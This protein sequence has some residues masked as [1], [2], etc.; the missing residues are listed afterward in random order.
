MPLSA[1]APADGHTP[2]D[3]HSSQDGVVGGVTDLLAR[4][5]DGDADAA[6]RA[7]ELLRADLV[8]VARSLRRKLHAGQ[9]LQTTALIHEAY[10]RMAG[11][12][13]PPNSRRHYL[14]MA[15]KA[16]RWILIEHYRRRHS[17]RRNYGAVP[18]SLDELVQNIPAP[19]SDIVAT[20]DLLTK[21][22]EIDPRRA[23]VA[24]LRIFGGLKMKEVA[25][26]LGISESTAYRCRDEAFAWLE[27][28]LEA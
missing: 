12:S 22:A 3:D 2:V 26:A 25:D 16:M 4:A 13:A 21:L 15:A 5:A 1:A 6:N 11:T 23:Q 28:A 19:F 20:D 18:D 17:A 8:A 27:S 7:Q 10:I 24:E 14:C 9:T